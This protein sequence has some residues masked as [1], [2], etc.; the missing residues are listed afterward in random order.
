VGNAAT[1]MTERM[2]KGVPQANGTVE[3]EPTMDVQNVAK[4]V[5]YM[6]SLPLDANVQFLTVMATKMPFVGRG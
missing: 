4:A 6:A 1:E 2:K 3:V 5:V